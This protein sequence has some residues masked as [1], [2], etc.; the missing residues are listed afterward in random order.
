MRA[1]RVSFP[2]TVPGY[3]CVKTRGQPLG[4]FACYGHTW[5]LMQYRLIDPYRFAFIKPGGLTQPL[6]VVITTGPGIQI[7]HS[8]SSVGLRARTSGS[9]VETPL[10]SGFCK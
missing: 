10:A 9:R 2:G 7:A 1:L 8:E 6:P 4:F 3:V 5:P